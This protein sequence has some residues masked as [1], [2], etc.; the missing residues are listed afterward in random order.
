MNE[1]P[2]HL[3]DEKMKTITDRLFT[4]CGRST[5]R[6]GYKITDDINRVTC[7]KCAAKELGFK[8]IKFKITN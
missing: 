8:I 6:P 2:I 1:R 4:I 3:I 7:K 5:R